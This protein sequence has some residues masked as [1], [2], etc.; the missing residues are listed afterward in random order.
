MAS[1]QD[2]PFRRIAAT[3]RQEILDGKIKVGDRMPSIPETARR[4]SVARQT[5][6]RALDL[7]RSEGWTFVRAGSG[8]YLRTD[9]NN[10]RPLTPLALADLRH[11]TD[12]MD[13]FPSREDV[14]CLIATVD[15][16]HARIADLESEL[17]HITGEAS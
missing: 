16:A 11:Q 10:I 2:P 12:S 13:Y 15:Q 8:T 3:L 5:A 4:F 14:L 7:L 6:Q 17:A 9:G 1:R